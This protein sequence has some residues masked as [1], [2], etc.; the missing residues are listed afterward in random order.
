[1]M[2]IITEKPK[3]EYGYLSV[4]PGA[5]EEIEQVDVFAAIHRHLAGDWGD[6]CKED[7]EANE[8]ALIVG[9]RL[10]SVYKDRKGTKFWIITEA[11]RHATTVLLPS[12]Y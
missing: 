7:W 9:S 11:G 12:E 4:T 5:A 8:E 6:C 2:L 1:M 3:F 10:F